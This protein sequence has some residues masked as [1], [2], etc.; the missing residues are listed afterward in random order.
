MTDKLISDLGAIGAAIADTTV[1]E[2]QRSGQTTTEKAAGTDLTTYVG[3]KNLSYLADAAASRNNLGMLVPCD[4]DFNDANV[5]LTTP[6]TYS[7]GVLVAN[8]LYMIPIWVPRTRTYTTYAVVSTVLAGTSGIRVGL[9]NANSSLQPTTKIDEG[10]TQVD[11]STGTGV[12]GRKT[13]AFGVNQ[14]LKPGMYFL[15][16]LSDGAPTVIRLAGGGSTALGTQFA[17]N[18]IN[19]NGSRYRDSVTYTTLPADETAQTYTSMAGGGISAACAGI[20]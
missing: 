3:S 2:A 9:Y 4:P 5:Y 18:A 14:A 15:A 10:A 7:A 11:T 8:R 12:I 1:F 16:V 6:G 13:V 19:A 17:T 20:R